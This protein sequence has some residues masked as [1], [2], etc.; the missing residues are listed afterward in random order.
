[1]LAPLSLS[2]SL[3]RFSQAIHI[4]RHET[5]SNNLPL[6]QGIRYVN[7]SGVIC[8]ALKSQEESLERL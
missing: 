5:A 4:I 8:G 7:D 2:L 6:D 1:V 3:Q